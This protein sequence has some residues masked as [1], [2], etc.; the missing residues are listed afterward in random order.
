[1]YFLLKCS[2][3]FSLTL[4][5]PLLQ[6]FSGLLAGPMNHGFPLIKAGYSS[7]V[8]GVFWWTSDLI[9]PP[10]QAGASKWT[11]D[12]GWTAIAGRDEMGVWRNVGCVRFFFGG[13]HNMEW[14]WCIYIYKQISMT[15]LHLHPYLHLYLCLG[16]GAVSIVYIYIYSYMHAYF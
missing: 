15:Y 2:S 7:L 1:M 6:K 11:S 5:D 9:S 12:L 14:I 8:S 4:K 10:F 13:E 3:L 16:G